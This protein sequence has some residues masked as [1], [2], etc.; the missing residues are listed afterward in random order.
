M[1]NRMLFIILKKIYEN[2]VQRDIYRGASVSGVGR[3]YFGD[4]NLCTKV[5]AT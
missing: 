3:R 4:V 5:T 1:F 2:L